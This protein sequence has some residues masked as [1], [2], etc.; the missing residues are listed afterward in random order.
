MQPFKVDWRPATI[1]DVRALFEYLAENASLWD[2]EHVTERVLRCTDKLTE[3]PR[4]YEADPRYGE[5]VRRI[6][7]VGQNILYEVD[8]EQRSVKIL[9]VVRQ[10]QNPALIR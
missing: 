6:S 7:V 3:F 5:G 2:A 8:D 9:A 10:R 1:E 4:L